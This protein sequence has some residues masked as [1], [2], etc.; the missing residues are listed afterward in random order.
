MRR[1]SSVDDS[2]AGDV[3]IDVE[4][5]LKQDRVSHQSSALAHL[6]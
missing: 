4:Q 3:D 1:N 2:E 6:Y 5:Q